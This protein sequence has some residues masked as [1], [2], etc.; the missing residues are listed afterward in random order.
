MADVRPFRGLRYNPARIDPALVL[1][2]P[3]DV[4][5]PDEQRELYARS[6]HNVVRLEYG[7]QRE[8]DSE[9]DNRYTRAARDLAEWR[10][11]GVLTQDREPMVYA[12]KQE[13]QWGGRLH[14]RR[15]HFAVVRL[16]EW[17]T[18]AVKPHERTLAKPKADRLELLRATR[19]QIS[20][21]YCLFRGETGTAPSPV[22]L[23]RAESNGEHHA[24]S[25]CEEPSA[26][27]QRLSRTQ[28]YVADGHHRYETALAYRDEVRA[29]AGGW[30][31][32]APEN[33][34]LV[35]LTD[36]HD[37]GL[38]V[39]PTH[40][41]VSVAAP[42]DA[43]ERLRHWFDLDDAGSLDEG[44]AQLSRAGRET[45]AFLAAGLAPGRLHLVRLR[46]RPAVEALMPADQ[47]PAWKRLDVNVLQYAVLGSVLGIDEAA[48]T[49]GDAV[50]YTQHA[51]SAHEV[52]ASGGAGIAFMLNATPVEHVLAV[53]DAGARM[54]QKSTYFYPKLPT[55]LVMHPFD[56]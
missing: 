20:P 44:L 28:L 54:P 52:V 43:V 31:G 32:D 22:S 3:Y 49:A 36:A 18:G 30:T 48:L 16:E 11:S 25:A 13:F 51:R 39:L 40:R 47:P 21:V 42:A 6:E 26:I 29:A 45:T 10:G 35:A 46:D 2:P 37:P 53:A 9:A 56:G 14:I 50:T 8:G 27:A 24:L 23:L 41:V 33:F 19:T 55:G 38:L 4:I 12:Y 15:A 17:A 1:A 34:V 7:E 5:S